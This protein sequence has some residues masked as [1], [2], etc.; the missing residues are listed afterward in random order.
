MRKLI[1]NTPTAQSEIYIGQGICSQIGEVI[2]NL[3]SNSRVC[4]ICDSNVYPLHADKVVSYIEESGFPTFTFTVKAGEEYK[5]L[6]TVSDILNFL[7]ENAFTRSD[8]I[9][10]LGGGVIGDISGFVSAIYLRGIRCI[11]IPTTLLAQ[12]DSSVGGKCGVDLKHGKNLVGAFK[13]PDRVIID[14][15][16]LKTLPEDILT[17]GTAEVIKYACIFD[18]N[19]FH[20]LEELTPGSITEE[21]IARCVEL[22]RDVV[23]LDE[24]DKGE[25]MLLNFGH[26]VGHAIEKLGNFTTYSH[27]RA[28]A[29]GMLSAIRLGQAIGFTAQGTYEKVNALLSRFSLSMPLPYPIEDIIRVMTLDKKNINNNLNFILLSEYGSGVISPMSG[30]EVKNNFEKAYSK[31]V[32]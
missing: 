14:T 11:Q 15:D 20:Q 13:Q 16:F 6:D 2:R 3:S 22:K 12:V 9:V 4:V 10:A 30:E 32:L 27:G 25:R 17:D 29:C 5:T 7:A 19:L 21:I 8:I 31:E 26:T 18:K 23:Q 28:V 1:L 24:H